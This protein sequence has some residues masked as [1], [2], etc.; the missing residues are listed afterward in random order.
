[1]ATLIENNANVSATDSSGRTP[2]HIAAHSGY[3]KIAKILIENGAQ[4][5][6]RDLNGWVVQ[7]IFNLNFLKLIL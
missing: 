3:E 6:E 7:M 1:M 4:V 2:L 5:D